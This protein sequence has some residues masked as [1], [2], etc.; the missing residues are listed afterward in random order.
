ML[1]SHKG[2]VKLRTGAPRG[3]EEIV[4]RAKEGIF[5]DGPEKDEGADE[6]TM[7]KVPKAVRFNEDRRLEEVNRMLQYDEPVVIGGDRTL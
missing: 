3:I 5:T 6:A 1:F 4:R 7:V 2:T